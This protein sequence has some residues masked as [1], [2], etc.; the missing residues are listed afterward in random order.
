M[1]YDKNNDLKLILSVH[2]SCIF[3]QWIKVYAYALDTSV[4]DAVFFIN[5]SLTSY[6]CL[7]IEI[8][9]KTGYFK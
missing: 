3:I 7:V 6:S 2:L 4:W 1:R 9:L 8:I 5:Y